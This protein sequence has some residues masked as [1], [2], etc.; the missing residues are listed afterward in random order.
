MPFCLHLQTPIY[1]V[2]L[3]AAH[4]DVAGLTARLSKVVLY[5]YDR[6][7]A[8]NTGRLAESYHEPN[9]INQVW[10]F[11]KQGFWSFAYC[12]QNGHRELHAT[13]AFFEW[14][15]QGGWDTMAQQDKDLQVHVS[16]SHL[17]AL[18]D[19]SISVSQQLLIKWFHFA[20]DTYLATIGKTKVCC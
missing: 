2:S 13:Q 12:P 19:F 14:Q 18:T 16:Y 17:S 8:S 9:G 1:H 11:Y 5:H 7:A 20:T 4:A 10:A 3:K 15:R 6:M